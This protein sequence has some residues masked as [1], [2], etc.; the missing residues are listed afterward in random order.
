M[1]R[2]IRRYGWVGIEVEVE[3]VGVGDVLR[4]RRGLCWWCGWCVRRW[5]GRWCRCRRRRRRPRRWELDIRWYQY[6]YQ[7]QQR[8]H[9]FSTPP[10]L[11]TWISPPIRLHTHT[12]KQ[13]IDN[14]EKKNALIYHPPSSPSLGLNACRQQP[15]PR[16]IHLVAVKKKS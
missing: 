15:C 12:Y 7:Q 1:A 5:M 10:D 2:E 4:F 3:V 14:P 11:S 8:K 6:Q 16:T 13:P 9:P